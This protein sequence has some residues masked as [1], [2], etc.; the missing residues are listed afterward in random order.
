M[1]EQLLDFTGCSSIKFLLHLCD[2]RDTMPRQRSPFSSHILWLLG[3]YATPEIASLISYIS[4][5]TWT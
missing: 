1:F 5:P 4:C 2:L 3:H